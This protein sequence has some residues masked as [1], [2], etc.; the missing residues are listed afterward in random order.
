M[1][2]IWPTAGCNTIHIFFLPPTNLNLVL[3]HWFIAPNNLAFQSGQIF[4]APS[5]T[6]QAVA[7]EDCCDLSVSRCCTR[8]ASRPLCVCICSHKRCPLVASMPRSLVMLNLVMPSLICGFS[9]LD[10]DVIY[11]HWISTAKTG[12]QWFKT[13]YQQITEF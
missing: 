9:C 12:K 4:R 5:S 1:K 13:F 11:R 6:P 10:Q 3:V 8:R 2:H 7:S